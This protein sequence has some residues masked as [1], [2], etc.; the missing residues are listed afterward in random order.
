MNRRSMKVVPALAGL[1]ASLALPLTAS[2]QDRHE[3]VLQGG[4]VSAQ[5]R[6][7]YEHN[8]TDN[9]TDTADAGTLR[10][11]LG[12]R[13]R[14]MASNNLFL[15]FQDVTAWWRNYAPLDA[16]YDMVPDPE[17]TSVHQAYLENRSLPATRLRIGRQE[18]QFENGRFLAVNSWRQQGQ[19]LEAV[20]L[21]NKGLDSWTLTALYA[22]RVLTAANVIEDVEHFAALH[23]DFAGLEGHHLF[24]RVFLL[25]SV[26]GLPTD[27]DS[28]TYG[29]RLTGDLPRVEY[30]AEYDVQQGYADNDNDAGSMID[31]FAAVRFAGFRIGPGY[32][33]LTGA[34]GSTRAFD[35]LQGTTHAFNGYADQFTATRGGGLAPGVVDTYVLLGG[36]HWAHNWHVAYHIFEQEVSGDPYGTEIN[37]VVGRPITP[38]LNAE[39]HFAQYT[40]DSENESG[41]GQTDATKYWLR[42]DY[43]F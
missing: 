16:E 11:R 13:T 20:A 1:L 30:F 25:D 18:I 36:L 29:F 26:G 31:L 39:I 42:I 32:N 43:L 34:E 23:A 15:Q 33:V 3:P 41:F 5:L 12:Y 4:T 6:V 7:V 9:E 27:R 14:D 22:S 10:T 17:G 21:E 40:A 37:A 19:S 35:T 28:A 2:A 8:D 24:L 38:N